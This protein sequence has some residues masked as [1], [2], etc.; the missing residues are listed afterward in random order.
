MRH[1]GPILRNGA[2]E[3]SMTQQPIAQVKSG[4]EL[5]VMFARYKS[6]V[7]EELCRSVPSRR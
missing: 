1:L 2:N 3:R 6:W 5:P 4:P 7:E